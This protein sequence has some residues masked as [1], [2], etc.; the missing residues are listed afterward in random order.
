MSNVSFCQNIFESYLLQNKQKAAVDGKGLIQN[1]PVLRY[2]L[3]H[4]KCYLTHTSDKPSLSVKLFR[5]DIAEEN[6]IK[7]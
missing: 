3:D 5:K 1:P 6:K 7:R 2:Y 4:K